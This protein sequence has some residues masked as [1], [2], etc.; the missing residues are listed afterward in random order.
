MLTVCLVSEP[1]TEQCVNDEDE[2]QRKVDTKRCANKDAR[3]QME[4]N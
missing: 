3:L 1:N 4:V 2:P